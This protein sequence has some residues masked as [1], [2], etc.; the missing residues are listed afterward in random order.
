MSDPEIEQVLRNWIEQAIS[1]EGTFSGGTDR[2][3]WV[4][5][6]FIAWL[7]AHVDDSL[8]SAEL[9]AHRL[10]DEFKRLGSAAEFDEALHELTHVQDALSDLRRD[11]GLFGNPGERG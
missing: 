7:R 4:A 2:A 6:N 1:P 10:R 3:K 5:D 11:L 8:G 9:A